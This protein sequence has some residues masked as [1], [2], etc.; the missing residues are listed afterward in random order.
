M[1]LLEAK[2]ATVILASAWCEGNVL[3]FSSGHFIRM[4]AVHWADIEPLTNGAHFCL[5]LRA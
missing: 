4:L 1:I 3:R 5:R 2:G